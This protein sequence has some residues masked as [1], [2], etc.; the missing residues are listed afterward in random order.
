M[1]NVIIGGLSLSAVDFGGGDVPAGSFVAKFDPMGNHVWS[2]GFGNTT[3]CGFSDPGVSAIGITPQDDVIIAGYFCGTI[4]FD[5]GPVT[6]P[7]AGQW[8]FIEKLR[9]ADGSGKTGD[10][11]EGP[12][13]TEFNIGSMS[14]G[15]ISDGPT[16]AVDGAGN[17][18]LAAS[19][20]G[21][22]AFGSSVFTSAGASDILA[23]KLTPDGGVSWSKSFGG[24]GLD[25]VSGLTVDNLGALV[26][27]GFTGGSVDFGGGGL[28]GTNGYLVKLD[29]T[30]AYQW[31]KA[32]G[33]NVLAAD[34]NNNI[35]LA[36]TLQG[37]VNLGAG[38]LTSAGGSEDV[39]VA[40]FTGEGTVI[41]NKRYGDS[42]DQ[43]ANGVGLTTAGEPIISGW[44]KGTID[45][46]T[47][48]LTSAGGWD[49]FIAK[50]SQ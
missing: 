7:Q 6:T 10:G 16:L 49:G 36:G 40:K 14:T 26:L 23:A 29:T 19:Y 8:G 41:W 22:T 35:F 25:G 11:G 34:K 1:G 24:P 43:F 38:P 32:F 44:A 39:L 30:G 27:T 45:F 47:G 33:G 3:L 5:D 31:G 17:I 21:M 2:K 4:E 18:L 42:A 28:A 48:P 46:G 20:E 12:W 50:L 15:S 9:G 13:T 37:T